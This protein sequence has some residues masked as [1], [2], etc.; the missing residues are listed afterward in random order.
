MLGHR[1]F[2][3]S[4]DLFWGYRVVIDVNRVESL[5]DAIQ[6][7]KDDLIL[8]LKHRNLMTLAEKVSVLTLH[9]HEPMC[10]FS[11]LLS[12]THPDQILYLCGHDH[13][14]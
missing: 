5:R 10:A 12:N 13:S 7:V 8:Y 11:E 3:I 9:M 2:Q 14:H 1:I 6:L 4:D